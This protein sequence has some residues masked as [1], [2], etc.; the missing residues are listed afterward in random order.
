MRSCSRPE[1]GSPPEGSW[2][3][4]PRTCS[5]GKE[6][7]GFSGVGLCCSPRSYRH[8]ADPKYRPHRR[9]G[10]IGQPSGG[11]PCCPQAALGSHPPQPRVWGPRRPPAGADRAVSGTLPRVPPLW[12]CKVGHG[13]VGEGG[14]R[15]PQVCAQHLPTLPASPSPSH[16]RASLLSGSQSR[17]RPAAPGEQ[18]SPHRSPEPQGVPAQ[19]CWEQPSLGRRVRVGDTGGA[20]SPEAGHAQRGKHRDADAVK[21]AGVPQAVRRGAERDSRGAARPLGKGLAPS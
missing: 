18:G 8:K 3:L 13:L 21:R 17:C 12:P 11:S 4:R 10:Q 7:S 15:L 9:R 19:V 5:L 20:P 16:P 1:R 14:P 2:Q 6:G